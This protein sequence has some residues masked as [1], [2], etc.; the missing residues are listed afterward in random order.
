[1]LSASDNWPVLITIGTVAGS[2]LVLILWVVVIWAII[3]S[4]VLSALRKHADEERALEAKR[5]RNQTKTT[6]I[7]VPPSE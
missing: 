2:L 7:M 4:A 5:E 6:R 1:M 3:R